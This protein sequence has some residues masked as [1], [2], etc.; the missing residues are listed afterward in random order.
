[1]SDETQDKSA[2]DVK[3]SEGLSSNEL[4]E[5]SGGIPAFG[6]EQKMMEEGFAIAAS[7]AARAGAGTS[8]SGSS[9]SGTKTGGGTK[10]Q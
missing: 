1:M 4:R 10:P 5:V 2:A 3:D 8:T 7:A 6:A 9:S